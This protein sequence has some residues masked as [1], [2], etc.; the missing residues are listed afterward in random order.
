[1]SPPAPAVRWSLA[2]VVAT[3]F[4]AGL[5]PLAPGTV[6]TLA[7][8]PLLFALWHVGW[9]CVPA[10]ALVV[11][12]VGVAAGGAVARATGL[13]D[14]QQVVIDEAA[15]YLLAC[16]ASPAGWRTAAIAFVLF[17][18]IDACKPGPI[19]RLERLP[20]GWGV[21]A[22]DLGAGALAGAITWLCWGLLA[23]R[24]SPWA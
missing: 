1:M 6:G 14:P 2:R 22:D 18:L 12:A 3:W 20:G 4:G 16:S 9:W 21:M 23:G 7:T 24:W 17:R 13:K 5:A 10:G 11:T 19:A 15:G 8:A